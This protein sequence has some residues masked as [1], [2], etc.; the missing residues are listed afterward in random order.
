MTTSMPRRP[1]GRILSG[2]AVLAVCLWL[3]PV[4]AAAQV[5]AY[6]QAVAES[7]ARDEELAAFYR[8]RDFHAVWGGG[9]LAAQDRRNALLTALADA[10][11]HGLPHDRYDAA[12][13]LAQLKAAQTPAQQGAAD[14]ALTAAFL[15]YARDVATGILI[16]SEVVPL[17]VREVPQ[18]PRIPLLRQFLASDD[19]ASFL[20]ALAPTSPEYVRLLHAKMR[21]EALAAQGGYGPA[22]TAASLAPGATGPDVIALR[23]RLIRMGHLD[24]TATR[25]YD[26]TLQAAVTRL[27]RS[28]GLTEDGTAGPATMT[29]INVPLEDR[30]RSVVVAMERE[31]WV[32]APRGDRHVWVNLADFTAAIVDDDRVTFST[33]SVI[34]ALDANR[35]TPE[36]SDEMEFMVVNP[37]WYVPRSIIVNEYLPQLQQNAGAV[38]HIE[39]T[40]RDGR[41]IPRGAVN[42][43]RYTA[44]TFPFAMRQ[45][46]GPQNALGLVKFMFPNEYNIYLHDTPAK[47]LF[48]REA[49]AFSHGCVRLNDPLAFAAALLAVQE[50]D[51]QQFLDDRLRGGAESRVNL[52]VAVPVHLDYRTAFTGVTGGLQFRRDVYGRD[53]AIWQALEQAGVVVAAVQG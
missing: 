9:D 49:R 16:P 45:P 37:S 31:R 2:A 50:S 39:V 12:G 10:P 51:P 6:R 52:D 29:E 42:A 7:A 3:S 15:A 8:D 41:V 30:L 40:D 34:G 26:A 23:N 22:V 46:P 21:L 4:T 38:G 44:R 43:N 32:S 13:L 48:S 35:Q 28:M 27:Q 5:T 1:T 33:R 18:A 11:A 14:V 36:F 20:R 53:A 19:P 17:I 25:T 47:A 24:R